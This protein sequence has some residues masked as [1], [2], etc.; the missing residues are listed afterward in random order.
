MESPDRVGGDAGSLPLDTGGTPRIDDSQTRM[1]TS[2][3][4]LSKFDSS[5]NRHLFTVQALRLG[6][7]NM[8]R[9]CETIAP[10]DRQ[11][12]YHASIGFC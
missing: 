12:T 9:S 10:P 5:L 8:A 4:T 2:S 1:D 3:H 7:S 6:I 11:H